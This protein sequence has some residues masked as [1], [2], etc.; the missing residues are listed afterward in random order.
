MKKIIAVAGFL[1]ALNFFGFS[2]ES[3]KAAFVQGCKSYSQGDWSAAKFMLKKAVSYP[4]NINPDTYYMLI[5][6]EINDDDNKSALDDCN[7]YLEK[8]PDSI[9]YPRIT[10]QKGKVLYNLGE[11]EKSIITLSDFC[12]Q[13]ED[14][15]LYSYAL[16]YI[17]ESL[18]A[19][20]KYDEARQIYERVVTE[21]PKSEKT[22]AA[23]YRIDT[24]DQRGREEKLIYLLKQ[25]GEEYLSAKEDYEKQ[26]RLYN[27]DTI[28]NTRERLTETQSR[29]EELERQ[30]A[31]LEAQ[32]ETLRR[33]N[34]S[35]TAVQTAAQASK[36]VDVPNPEP[37][38]ETKESLRKL[39]AKA[40]EAQR[41]IEEKQ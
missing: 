31:D 16:F 17:G 39:K 8:F 2:S 5:S 15:E 22:P 23:Q 24:I 35:Q 18:F 1:C 13:Y 20:Y 29:N 11:Y 12:H 9:Y 14:N 27:S 3:A 28:N 34:S 41:I 33:E 4:Q 30:V 10:Y 25:T 6:S 32:I 21:F 40:L 7:I 19:G 37:Y 36:E 38:D 26:L